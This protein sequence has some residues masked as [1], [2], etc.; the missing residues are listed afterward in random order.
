MPND[1]GLPPTSRFTRVASN[2]AFLR[3]ERPLAKANELNVLF[4]NDYV[5]EINPDPKTHQGGVGLHG[6]T[7]GGR[8][9]RTIGPWRHAV[10]SVMDNVDNL[11][12]PAGRLSQ[13]TTL[14]GCYVPALVKGSMAWLLSLPVA[15]ALPLASSDRSTLFSFGGSGRRFTD[16]VLAHVR[17]IRFPPAASPFLQ[18]TTGLRAKSPALSRRPIHGWRRETG[19]ADRKPALSGVFSLRRLM[20]SHPG[21]GDHV[22]TTRGPR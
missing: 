17:R 22:A 13:S 10:G 18:W 12:E 7:A 1:G 19:W 15:Q 8:W 21:S 6:L 5:A 11:A 9:I 16:G 20:Q 4:P 2:S 14:W 3:R